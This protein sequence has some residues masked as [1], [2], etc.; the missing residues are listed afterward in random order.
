MPPAYL[1][2]LWIA[3]AILGPLWFHIKFWIVCSSSVKNVMGNLIWITLNLQ[4]ALSS[5]TILMILILAIQE[6]EISF[7]FESSLNFL[8]KYNVL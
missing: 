2:F 4:I 5:M 7:Y 3:L 1:L 6:H 8:E